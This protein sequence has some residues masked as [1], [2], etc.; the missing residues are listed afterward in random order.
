[1]S[2][3]EFRTKGDFSKL[4]NYLGSLKKTVALHNAEVYAKKG[5]EALIEATPKRTGLTS[6]SWT[7]QI[8]QTDTS[9]SIIYNNTNV[10]KGVVVAIVLDYG[11]FSNGHWI[12]GRHYIEPAIRPVFD[13]IANDLWEEITKS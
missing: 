4:Q 8:V 12:V 5:L 7:Y 2:V 10:Q 13:S 3:I 9:I 1:M 11:H 6:R